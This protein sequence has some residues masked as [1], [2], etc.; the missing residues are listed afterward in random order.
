MVRNANQSKR[1]K[2]VNQG[3]LEDIP[4]PNTIGAS[5]PFDFDARNLSDYDGLLPVATMLEK[6]GFLQ[7]VEESLTVMRKTRSMPIFG[8]ILGK[9]LGCYVGFSRLNRLRFLASLH[10]GANEE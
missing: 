3:V 4:E 5:T 9:V 7:L 1:R 8:F 10:F 6:L 2:L